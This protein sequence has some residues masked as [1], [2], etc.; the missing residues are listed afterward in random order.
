MAN[1][2]ISFGVTQLTLAAHAQFHGVVCSILA[3]ADL[4]A[5][6]LENLAPQYLVA[7]AAEKEA[8]NRPDSF[9]E[10][11]QMVEVDRKRDL[12]VSLTFNLVNAFLRSTNAAEI[13]AAQRM[14]AIISPYSAIQAHEYNRET[15]EIEGLLAALNAAPPADLNLLGLISPLEQ[16]DTHNAAFKAI[17]AERSVD[18]VARGPISE[19]DTRELRATLD[20]LY[21]QIVQTVNA[22][23]IAIPS[24][25]LDT[26]A[27][28]INAEIAQYKVVAANQ[29]KGATNPVAPIADKV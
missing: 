24:A 25:E 15:T 8:V 5:L 22:F 18:V 12:A 11:P 7:S 14:D 29:G 19:T 26:F 9:S 16:L 1:Q 23:A 10:T 17:K 3:E 4:A 20:T 6:H 21:R 13:A 27:A 2:I 28:A